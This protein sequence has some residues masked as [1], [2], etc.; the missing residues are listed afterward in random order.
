MRKVEKLTFALITILLV[1]TLVYFKFDVSQALSFLPLVLFAGLTPYL[2]WRY[3][4]YS[5][6]KAME[7]YF[8]EFLRSL[9]E[10]QRSGI[11][12]PQAIVNATK[13]DYGPLSEEIKKMAA[14]ITWGVPFPKVLKSFSE[15]VRESNFLRRSIAVILEAYRSGGDI[16]EVMSSV[17]ESA[18]MIKELEAER[19]SRF[20]QQ[21]M[22]M[23]A[24]FIIFLVII[25]ALNRILTP[26]FAFSSSQEIGGVSFGGGNLD[27]NFYR[28]IF[29]HMILM[30]AVFA[31]LL[32][33][34]VGEGS[35][36]AGVK[37]S[38][39]M[40]AIGSLVFMIFIPAQQLIIDISPPYEVFSPGATYTIEGT[41]LTAQR[42]PVADASVKIILEGKTYI[43]ATD[44]LGSFSQR[45]VLP[46]NPGRYEIV[47]EAS[48]KGGKG[49]RE[50]EVVVS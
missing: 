2:L 11:P 31:G 46:T 48:A 41:V 16:A 37:H 15:R 10:A 4:R 30:Q 14:Q 36:I 8:P 6:I 35:V 7:G 34:Q 27:P 29:L 42:I 20:N 38:L 23:Y 22:I 9:A 25:V 17:A 3:M 43:T 12:L 13:I 5:Q 19:R 50:V 24:I 18:R 1:A 26:M 32:A 21:L 45:I 47:I 44:P 39:V 40:L 33:G 49:R 28:T